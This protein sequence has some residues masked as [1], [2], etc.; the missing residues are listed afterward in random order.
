MST[1]RALTIPHPPALAAQ[2]SPRPTS[3]KGKAEKKGRPKKAKL[4][5]KQKKALLRQAEEDAIVAAAVEESEILFGEMGFCTPFYVRNALVR[6]FGN[7]YL[8]AKKHVRK[9]LEAWMA[10]LAAGLVEGDAM[11]EGHLVG[12]ADDLIASI[13]STGPAPPSAPRVVSTV[14]VRHTATWE[15]SASHTA[16]MIRTIA[17]LASNGNT[18]RLRSHVEADPDCVRVCSAAG[19]ALAHAA[20]RGGHTETLRLLAEVHPPLMGMLDYGGR[21]PAHEAAAE[22]H[23]ETLGVAL[24]LAPCGADGAARTLVHHAAASGDLETLAVAL[25][26]PGAPPNKWSA[27]SRAGLRPLH[28][29]A[30]RGTPEM[31]TLL[32]RGA[33]GNGGVRALDSQGRAAA[34]IAAAHGN[35]EALLSLVDSAVCLISAEERDRGANPT[36]A[37]LAACGGGTPLHMAAAGGHADAAKALAAVERKAVLARRACDGA[38]PMHV[39]A[40]AGHGA[41]IAMLAKKEPSAALSADDCGRLPLHLAAAGGHVKAVRALLKAVK[42]GKARRKMIRHPDAAGRTALH[43]AAPASDAVVAR[44]LEAYSACGVDAEGVKAYAALATSDGA[45]A[46]ALACGSNCVGAV[47]TLVKV[48]AAPLRSADRDGRIAAHRAAGVGAASAIRLVGEIDRGCLHAVDRRARTPAH[49]AAAGGH[50]DVLRVLI[51][52]DASCCGSDKRESAGASPAELAAAAG[53][54]AAAQLLESVVCARKEAAE[55]EQK[56]VGDGEDSVRVEVVRR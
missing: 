54:R 8:D 19:H 33:G 5:K 36:A 15:A 1:S 14:P 32:V 13:A 7:V 52:L 10:D 55:E 46:L 53:H 18:R 50:I 49:V 39:A 23:A 43:H 11:R 34:H 28:E 47:A 48:D 40:R 51:E 26:A 20:A 42:D 16:A 56:T 24:E 27:T 35:T 31:I 41:V 3:K 30:A 38:Q 12:R 22:A 37:T 4:T 45:V 9:A 17:K 44:L 29:A 6:R 2:S 21:L 25:A